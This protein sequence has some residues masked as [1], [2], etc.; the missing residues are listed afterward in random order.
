VT[1]EKLR[2]LVL[3]WL[4]F[5]RYYGV[6]EASIQG[7]ADDDT[8][9]VLPDDP[10]LRGD[11]LQRVPIRHGLPGVTVRVA[12]GSRCLL[13]FENGDPSKPYVSLWA[14]GSVTEIR[15]GG[16]TIGV[17]RVGDPVACSLPVLSAIGTL[18]GSPFAATL[19]VGTQIHGAIGSGSQ[20][21][22]AGGT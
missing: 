4:D 1:L 16:G 18:N 7:Q 10:K 15:F 20:K 13:G 21:V 12:E 9:D 17:A 22:L 6:Y 3:R 19:A 2:T 5:T 8:V 11:G 14:A